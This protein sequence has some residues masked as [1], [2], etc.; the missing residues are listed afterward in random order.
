[1]TAEHAAFQTDLHNEIVSSHFGIV[2]RLANRLLG[3]PEIAAAKDQ[4]IAAG[5]PIWQIIAAML[6]FILQ[7]I[8]GKPLDIQ[9]IIAAI[10]ALF[11]PKA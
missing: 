9:A 6:P 3:Q 2:Q 11:Q 8:S 1:M 10:L 4:A 7:L 5:I